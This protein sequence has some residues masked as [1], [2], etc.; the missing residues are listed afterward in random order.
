MENTRNE[1]IMHAD[2]HYLALFNRQLIFACLSRS[3]LLS[4]LATKD[5]W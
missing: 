4:A 1:V 2:L 3:C 5:C